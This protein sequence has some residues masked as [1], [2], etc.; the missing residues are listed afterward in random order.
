MGLGSTA[1][2]TEPSKG[3]IK[4]NAEAKRWACQLL[5]MWRYYILQTNE[6]N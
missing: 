1:P 3:L 4:V 6:D 5:L 2:L